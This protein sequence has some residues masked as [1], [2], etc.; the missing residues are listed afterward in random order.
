MHVMP[1]FDAVFW[2]VDNGSRKTA[3]VKM[4]PHPGRIVAEEKKLRRG[5]RMDGN[6]VQSHGVIFRRAYTMRSVRDRIG[7]IIPPTDMH[8]HRATRSANTISRLF[9]PAQWQQRKGEVM[10]DCIGY[11][12]KIQ[13]ILPIAKKICWSDEALKAVP[14]AKMWLGR[15]ANGIP[16]W[17]PEQKAKWPS[18]GVNQTLAF[19]LRCGRC[20]NAGKGTEHKYARRIALRSGTIPG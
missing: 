13:F 6:S 7:H 2:E 20:P 15:V 8:G 18:S 4:F 5:I 14:I 17:P 10:P 9:T 1:R 12:A 16:P 19:S 11:R 3:R